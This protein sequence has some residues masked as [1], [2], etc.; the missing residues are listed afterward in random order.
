[1]VYFLL[2]LTKRKTMELAAA[3]NLQ[4][5]T[6]DYV[7]KE[8]QEPDETNKQKMLETQIKGRQDKSRILKWR[9]LEE[10]GKTVCPDF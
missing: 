7:L 10:Q 1:M 3:P 5:H 2:D 9:W 8:N 6:I 4:V